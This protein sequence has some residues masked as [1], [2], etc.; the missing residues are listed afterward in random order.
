MESSSDSGFADQGK[1]IS[2][3]LSYAHT[4]LA[5]SQNKLHRLSKDVPFFDMKPP[6][7]IHS[8]QLITVEL[9]MDLSPLKVGQRNKRWKASSELIKFPHVD[10]IEMPTAIDGYTSLKEE[11]I[12]SITLS[13]ASPCPNEW[14]SSISGG[15]K[16]VVHLEKRPSDLSLEDLNRHESLGVIDSKH[17]VDMVDAALRL[18]ISERP[19]RT[20]RSVKIQHQNFSARLDGVAPSLFSPGYLAVW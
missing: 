8:V 10:A 15:N 14:Q 19:L 7:G 11:I 12:Q 16:T 4:A 1:A 13:E 6:D 3:E 2:I 17:L 5:G 9:R 18:T 20:S